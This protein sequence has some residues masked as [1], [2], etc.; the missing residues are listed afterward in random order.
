MSPLHVQFPVHA[1]VGVAMEGD[2]DGPAVDGFLSTKGHIR[3]RNT[4]WRVAQWSHPGHTV[5]VRKMV[6]A[7]ARA[8]GVIN[9]TTAF[10][11]TQSPQR[12]TSLGCVPSHVAQLASKWELVAYSVNPEDVRDEIVAR[13]PVVA[14]LHITD[15][16]LA[17]V[18]SCLREEEVEALEP[19]TPSTTNHGTVI[20]AVLGWEADD[21]VWVVALPWGKFPTWDGTVRVNR[22]SVMNVCGLARQE[23]VCPTKKDS[24]SSMKV[25]VLPPTWDPPTTQP[26]PPVA[27]VG[28][29]TGK[30]KAIKKTKPSTSTSSTS[31][32]PAPARPNWRAWMTN[33]H[34]NLTVQCSVTVVV[35]IVGI[36][37]L[38]LMRRRA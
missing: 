3:D 26:L 22:T 14:A 16:L 17:C 24:G 10:T 7:V 15:A 21:D 27:N 30:Q 12:T 19:V 35:I 29:V 31:P 20:V 23:D 36:L 37:T 2:G 38:F 32:A 1:N 11:V 25:S 4:P 6:A 9:R 8:R 34:I 18:S 28:S 5:D 13:G 33:D